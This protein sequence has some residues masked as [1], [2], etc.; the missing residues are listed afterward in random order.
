MMNE[1][2]AIAEDYQLLR[3]PVTVGATGSILQAS[4][5]PKTD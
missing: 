3:V 4:Q 2:C 5:A 1:E